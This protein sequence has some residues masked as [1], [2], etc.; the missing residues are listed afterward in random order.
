MDKK[1][2]TGDNGLANQ[3]KNRRNLRGIQQ[4]FIETYAMDCIGGIARIYRIA[5]WDPVT[6]DKLEG[7]I[8]R[9]I[10]K[11][12]NDFMT[13]YKEKFGYYPNSNQT[14]QFECAVLNAAIN[15]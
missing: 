3:T 4:E 6:S 13:K 12:K 5:S 14:E 15:Y 11:V 7:F 1:M 9:N 8:R 10:T 2:T